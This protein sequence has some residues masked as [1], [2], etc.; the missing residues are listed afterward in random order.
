M[1]RLDELSQALLAGYGLKLDAAGRDSLTRLAASSGALE[2]L[3]QSLLELA[4]AQGGLMRRSA[5]DLSAL[6]QTIVQTLRTRAPERK[7]NVTIAQGLTAVGDP[8]L[9]RQA[10]THLI[11]N[12]WAFTK[13]RPI[14][15]IEFGETRREG[16]QAYLVRDDGGGFDRAYAGPLPGAIQRLRSSDE[17][18]GAGTCPGDG[19]ADRAAPRRPRLVRGKPGGRLVFFHLGRAARTSHSIR[20]M[21]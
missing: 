17:W 7:V 21:R 8:V 10:L 13:G 1:R 4:R 3:A 19:A 12:A 9:L 20:L 2:R 6:A 5:I 15:S 16:C 11:G 14:A 18:P